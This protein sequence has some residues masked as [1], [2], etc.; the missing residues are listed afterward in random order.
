MSDANLNAEEVFR[1]TGDAKVSDNFPKLPPNSKG[2]LLI[3]Q[4]KLIDGVDSGPTL[5]I[6]HEIVES[7]SDQCKPGHMYST[8]IT[9]L[10]GKVYSEMKKG[11]ARKFVAAALNKDH[12]DKSQNWD[13]V[14]V[15]CVTKNALADKKVRYIAGPR[16]DSK[17]GNAYTPIEFFACTE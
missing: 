14:L 15:F 7:D 5:V 13:R 16:K 17:G 1:G 6:E 3:K 10:K 4:M 12:E 11:Q 2:V 8:T 9:H